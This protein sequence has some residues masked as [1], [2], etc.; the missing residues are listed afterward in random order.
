MAAL[1]RL[2]CLRWT[3]RG[4]GSRTRPLHRL[5]TLQMTVLLHRLLGR[6]APKGV[7]LGA[8]LGRASIVIAVTTPKIAV[9]SVKKA[10]AEAAAGAA[11]VDTTAKPV[12]AK[13][14]V[15]AAAV[16]VIAVIVIAIVIADDGA[17]IGAGA[18]LAVAVAMAVMIVMILAIGEKRAREGTA[19]EGAVP[20][21]A[22][23]VAEGGAPAEESGAGNA[24]ML[25]TLEATTL[26]LYMQ[27]ET[28]WLTR[29]CRSLL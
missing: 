6:E 13:A 25:A 16:T 19:G 7:I 21:A 14:E 23:I 22:A 27:Q 1:R 18:G 29:L 4:L 9:E 28:E 15:V 17:A 26:M 10:A 3:M 24:M 5:F 20:A 11:A 8:R 2:R 12:A